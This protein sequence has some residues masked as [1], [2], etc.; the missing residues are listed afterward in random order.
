M[1][2]KKQL[3]SKLKEIEWEDFEV[4]RAKSAVPKNSWETVSAFANTKGGYLIFGIEETEKSKFKIVGVDD[5]EKMHNDFITTLRSEKFK[6]SFSAKSAKKNIN[7]KTIL[8][9]YI[10]EMPRQVKPLYFDNNPKNTFI[11]DGG[12]DLRATEKE[13]EKFMRESSESSSDSMK[14]EDA[15][16]G[17]LRK[18]TIERFLELFRNV[19]QDDNLAALSWKELLSRKG[20]LT[21]AKN[22]EKRITAAAILQ[23]GTDVAIKRYFPYYKIDY[24]EISGT[25]WGGVGEKRWDY[26]IRSE[27]NLFETYQMIMPRLKIRVPVPFAL[28]ED[29]ITRDEASPAL[30]AIREAFVNLLV[31]TDYFDRKGSSIKVYDNRIE[32]FNGGALLFDKELLEDGD[33]SEPRNPII[34]T[35]YRMINLAEDAGSG[36]FKINTSWEKA[37]FP[38]P[39]IESNRRDNYFKLAFEFKSSTPQ[40]PR[41]HQVRTKPGPS[42]DQV[43]TKLGLSQDQVI[44]LLKLC[45]K[46]ATIIALMKELNWGHRT[47]FRNKFLNPLIDEKLIEM[48]IPGKP[49]SPNQEYVIT[50]KG[51]KLLERINKKE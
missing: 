51:K 19:T 23:F 36:F 30:I 32:L 34:I 37:G 43:G 35:G 29:N 26:R 16:I 24:F 38:R 39:K 13:L 46:P 12:S 11:R 31:H 45:L 9:F 47:K 44:K 41:K 48:T 1:L 25:K 3:S 4:K 27:S 42:W 33:I 14:F 18:D 6:I 10:P 22:G 17:D 15:T 49:T 5:P 21:K 40:A 50:E 8:I 7:G 2:T 28:K 20:F